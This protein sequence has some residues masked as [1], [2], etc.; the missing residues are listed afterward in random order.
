M[1]KFLPL[2]LLSF[3][4]CS[5]SVAAYGQCGAPS[6]QP[7]DKI[8]ATKTL[9][10]SFRGFVQGDYLHAAIKKEHGDEVS[11][12]VG[13]SESVTYF[14]VA[15]KDEFL[16]L[17]YQV[18]DAYIPEAGGRQTIERLV[19]VKSGKLTN[20]EWWRQQKAKSSVAKLRKKYDALVE[21]SM[22]HE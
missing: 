20:A 17:T 12:F 4:A 13:E 22:L 2:L 16:T 6:R 1:K 15:H 21:Q 10:G 19:A 9:Q 5:A 8:K 7:K 14:L 3:I 18:V 11:L